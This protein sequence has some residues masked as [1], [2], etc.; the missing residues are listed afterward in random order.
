MITI[1]CDF[2]QEKIGAFLKNQCY[3]KILQ[4]LEVFCTNSPFFAKC[5]EENISKIIS[6]I[7][8]V[9]PMQHRHYLLRLTS[10]LSVDKITDDE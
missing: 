1:F 8:N 3:F 2:L 4:K 5:F 6:N 7:G 9:D 10:V